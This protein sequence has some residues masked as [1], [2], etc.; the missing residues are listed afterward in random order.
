MQQLRSVEEEE[1]QWRQ[2]DIYR[3]AWEGDAQ[4]LQ[5]L[6]QADGPAICAVPDA[7]E[8]GGGFYPAHYAAYNGH[9]DCV[10][11][12]LML[13]GSRA[14]VTTDNHCTP[15]FFAAQQGHIDCVQ[16]LLELGADA[17]VRERSHGL[18]AADVAYSPEVLQLIQTNP[19]FISATAK[20]TA[21]GEA[22]AKAVAEAKAKAAEE[23]KA[24]AAAEATVETAATATATADNA[25]DVVSSSININ[26]D[27]RNNVTTTDDTQASIPTSPSTE[28]QQQQQEQQQ[29]EQQKATTALATPTTTTDASVC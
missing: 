1:K 29:Q 18:N 8:F 10:R 21:Q 9:S 2:T 11:V 26:N 3:A 15:I 20:E 14:N 27:N 19:K 12:L 25:N 23:A 7:S 16:L 17:S 6:I 13:S 5:K 24:K 4:Y 22:K 28:Q